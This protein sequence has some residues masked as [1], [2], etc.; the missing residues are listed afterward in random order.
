MRASLPR[1]SGVS[2]AIAAVLLLAA[3]AD[4]APLAPASLTSSAVSRAS[5]QSGAVVATLRRATARYHDV[6]AAVADG[7]VLLHPCESRPGEGPVGALYVHFARLLDGVVDPSLPDALLYEPRGDGRPRLV[8]VEL[9]VLD[10]GQAAPTLL[11]H[12]FQPEEEFGVFALH[13]WVW[14]HNPEG[15]FAEANPRISCGSE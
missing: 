2:L 9:A 3:C 1:R 6:D 5:D 13:A 15:M 14:S 10:A 12:R 7:F 4:R 11:G 8:G